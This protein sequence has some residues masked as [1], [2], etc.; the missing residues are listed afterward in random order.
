MPSCQLDSADCDS[1]A[2]DLSPEPVSLIS[3]IRSHD[4]DTA[5]D[6]GH[7]T[8]ADILELAERVSVFELFP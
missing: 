8:K 6:I 7:M 5:P 1:G 3:L 2:R 4:G